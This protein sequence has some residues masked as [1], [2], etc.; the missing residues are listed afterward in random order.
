MQATLRLSASVTSRPV[1]AQT[2]HTKGSPAYGSKVH[3]F[4]SYPF[5]PRVFFILQ[6]LVVCSGMCECPG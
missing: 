2:L 1:S 3:A 5:R 6:L 4:Q